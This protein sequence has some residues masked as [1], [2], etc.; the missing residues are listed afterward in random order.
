[1]QQFLADWFR[2]Q[3]DQANADFSR[4]PL[5][6]DGNSEYDRLCYSLVAEAERLCRLRFGTAPSGC[7]LQRALAAAEFGR[8][9]RDRLAQPWWKKG[10]KKLLSRLRRTR[11]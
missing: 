8:S 1:M 4:E 11:K 3:L 7:E 10:M 9:R 2:K 6:Y 5:S